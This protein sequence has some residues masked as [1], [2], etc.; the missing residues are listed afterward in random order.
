M[1]ANTF[2][3]FVPSPISYATAGCQRSYAFWMLF[4]P[5][6]SSGF[7]LLCA[8][9]GVLISNVIKKGVIFDL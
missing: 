9:P 7:Q 1:S 5:P 2:A 3:K 8:E 6:F 4:F